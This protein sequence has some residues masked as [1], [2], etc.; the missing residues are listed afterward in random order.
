MWNGGGGH[1]RDHKQTSTQR[2]AVA[3]QHKCTKQARA[4]TRSSKARGIE[5]DSHPEMAVFGT[6]GVGSAGQPGGPL[7]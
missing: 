4:D 3:I 5:V 2:P 1:H 7:R 6:R